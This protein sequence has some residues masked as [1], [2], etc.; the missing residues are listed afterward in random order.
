M[1]M[2]RIVVV[3]DEPMIRAGLVK[4]ISQ[5]SASDSCEVKALANGSAAAEYIRQYP[6]DLVLTDIRMPKMDGLDLCKY[7]ASLQLPIKTVVI[8]GYSDF[9]YAQKCLSYGVKEYLLKPVTEKELHPVLDKML[10]K[11]AEYS[12]SLVHYEEW[13]EKVEAAVWSVNLPLLSS[14]VQEWEQQVLVHLRPAQIKQVVVDG[15]T[16]LLKKLNSRNVFSFQANPSFNPMQS[17]EET[18]AEL[19]GS[20]ITLCQQLSK[21]RGGQEK[22]LFE[23]AKAYIDQHITDEISLET[24]AD[25]IGFAPTYFSFYFKKMTNETFVQYRIKKRIEIAKKLLEQPHYKIVDVGMEV[26]YQNYP[27]FTKIFKKMTG[28]SPTEYRNLIGIK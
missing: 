3:D 13:L 24:V 25:K 1:P 5:Y 10:A 20:L 17:R 15:W 8:S 4:L 19:K 23:E 16:L 12:L 18:V 28:L 27:H 9:A 2:V 22:N 7:I 14:L 26:G 6:P 11:D 21:W